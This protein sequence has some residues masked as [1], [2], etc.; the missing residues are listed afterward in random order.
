MGEWF[1]DESF[2]SVA[3]CSWSLGGR[4]SLWEVEAHLVT[5]VGMITADMIAACT[6]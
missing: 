3:W 4:S 2:W 5:T 1:E 6:A